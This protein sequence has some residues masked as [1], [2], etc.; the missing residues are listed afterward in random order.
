MSAPKFVTEISS[1][2]R[3]EMIGLKIDSVDVL[4]ANLD[5]NIVALS[6]LCTHARCRISSG[7]LKGTIAEC[8]CHGSRFDLLTGEVKAG[9]ASS[10]LRKYEVLIDGRR[11]MVKL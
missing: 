9:P 4:V 8:P 11:I 3:N 10:P 6:N 7:E 1:V 2:P 5:N